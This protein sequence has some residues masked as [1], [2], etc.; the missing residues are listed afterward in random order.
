MKVELTIVG[1]R[2]YCGCEEEYPV[3]FARLPIGYEVALRI[4]GPGEEYPG[5]V[6]VYDMEMQKIGNIAKTDRR[7]IELEILE[8][9]VVYATITGH[10]AEHNCI[11]IEA[12]NTQGFKEPY[13][14]VI[15]PESDEIVFDK[16]EQ[17]RRMELLTDMVKS[18]LDRLKKQD[19]T[20]QQMDSV[21]KVLTEYAKICCTSLDGESSFKRSDILILL[22]DLA[23]K[24]GMFQPFYD[25]IF[26]QTKDLGRSYID[27]GRTFNDKMVEAYRQQYKSIYDSAMKKGKKGKSQ[28]DEWLDNL[29]FTH[30]GTLTSNVISEEMER[31]AQ[32]LS[33][34]LMNKYVSCIDS[35]EDFATALYS[36]NYRL[37][38]IY[39]LYS[40]RIKYNYLKEI[41]DKTPTQ[42]PLNSMNFEHLPGKLRS[43]RAQELW[44]EL[45]IEGYVDNQCITTRSRIESAIIAAEMAE[46]L[47]LKQYWKEFS[48]LWQMSN[49][50]SA[51]Y[52]GHDSNQGWEFETKIR[53]LLS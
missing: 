48:E 34:E 30:A 13:L 5:S 32:K 38:S 1:I 27:N 36:L 39:V 2:H 20:E 33:G 23:Q 17:D 45:Y 53:H 6:S 9:G 7:F 25:D 46:R 43:P 52:K 47:G 14:R 11:Y 50:K 22:K 10:S 28:V 19:M 31:L 26:E 41:L 3:L 35:D 40:R 51:H 21:M 42:T 15:A 49:L 18:Q 29:K 24:Y 44:R 4:N 16:T 37:R 8:A 12:E